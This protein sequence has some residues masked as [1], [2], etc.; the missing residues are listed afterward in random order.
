MSLEAG[1]VRNHMQCHASK[2]IPTQPLVGDLVQTAIDV[3]K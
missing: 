3:K 1:E 2:Q